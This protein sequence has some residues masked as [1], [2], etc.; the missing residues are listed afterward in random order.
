MK[1]IHAL[2]TSFSA[3]RWEAGAL[4][5]IM[6]AALLLRTV[7][8]ST[9]PE[10]FH[11]D[12][13][14]VGLEAQRILSDGYIGPYSPYAA[15]Q[16]TGPMYLTAV[17]VRIFG[18]TVF[19]V[20]IVPA[21]LGTLTVLALYVVLRRNL[22]IRVALIGSAVLAVMSWHIHF[23]RIGFPL[24]AWPLLA[25][26]VVGA[27][28]EAMRNS[29]W[30]WW[31]VAGGLT[32]SGIYIYNAHPLLAAAV[33]LSIAVYVVTNRKVPLRRDL[34]GVAVFTL[35]LLVVL[36]PM[37]RLATAED[38]Y[39]RVHFERDRTTETEKWLAL[40]GPVEQ[41]RFLAGRY[42]DIWD[43]HCCKPELDD[44]DGSGLTILTPPIMLWLAGV[45]MLVGLWRYRRPLVFMGVLIVLVMPLG[46]VFVVGG[47]VR[48]TLVSAPFIAMFCAIA[49]VGVF[50]LAR[51]Q[52]RAISYGAVMIVAFVLSVVVYQ[53]VNLYFREFADP[54]IQRDIL[55]TPMADASK[56]LDDLPAGYYVYFYSNIWSIDHATRRYLAPD[57]VGEDRSERFG[58]FGF[59]IDPRKGKPLMVFLG[60][61][62]NEIETAR[63]LHPGSEITP[64]SAGDNP[65]FRVYEPASELQ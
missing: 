50:D 28:L 15:G 32:G 31:A 7:N 21:L 64:A 52:Q 59:E 57:V 3:K 13:A 37:A 8:L 39:Y 4:F 53:N 60:R 41:A 56:Y 23:A 2:L 12:E 9:F 1:T 33:L 24:E 45:G 44:V 26:L 18:N 40:E 27:V 11:G 10:G 49:A 17:S 43:R 29:D 61:Y 14:V 63:D 36:I 6:L 30:R 42:R 62:L 25:V 51:R 20:R 35:A 47:V 38:S 19:A 34:V 48:R 65:T 55:G 22:G 46:P 5:V 54:Q 16:P 58:E